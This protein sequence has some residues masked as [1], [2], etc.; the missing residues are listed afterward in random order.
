MTVQRDASV[1]T[2]S[3][4]T[5]AINGL[6]TKADFDL[7]TGGA[8]TASGT[9][10]VLVPFQAGSNQYEAI[11]LP[12]TTLTNQTVT[13][14]VGSDVY[15][16]KISDNISEFKRGEKYDMTVTLRKKALTVTGSITDWASED[17]SGTAK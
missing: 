9:P 16:W 14:T 5:V 1:P 8:L 4:L 17:R 7:K 2:L 12:A 10:T 6:N 13:F 15:T 3:G 11:L